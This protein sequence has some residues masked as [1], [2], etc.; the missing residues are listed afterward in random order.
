MRTPFLRTPW[1]TLLW[2]S[3]CPATIGGA[4][5]RRLPAHTDNPNVWGLQ[6]GPANGHTDAGGMIYDSKRDTLV[7]V[8]TTHDKQFFPNNSNSSSGSSVD[9]FVATLTL[10]PLNKELSHPAMT[11]LEGG[12]L[13]IVDWWSFSAKQRIQTDSKL[14]RCDFVTAVWGDLHDHY[15]A[16][17]TMAVDTNVNNTATA[18][19]PFITEIDVTQD[20]S[21]IVTIAAGPFMEVLRSEI[22]PGSPTPIYPTVNNNLI[23]PSAITTHGHTVYL[24]TIYRTLV[25]QQASSAAKPM[26]RIEL[27]IAKFNATDLEADAALRMQWSR[28]YATGIIEAKGD[29]APSVMSGFFHGDPGLPPILESQQHQIE[30]EISQLE[31][32]K[33]EFEQDQLDNYRH[34]YKNDGVLVSG[35]E[36]IE[37]ENEAD[38][39]MLISGSAPGVK[40]QREGG[41]ENHTTLSIHP[42]MNERGTYVGDWDGFISKIGA[43]DGVPL[44]PFHH[45]TSA[46]TSLGAPTGYQPGVTN[47]WTYT[48]KT[49]PRRDD[50]VQS[51]CVPRILPELWTHDEPYYPTVAYAIGSTTGRFDGNQDGG[52][53]VLQL[54][55][56]TMNINWKKQLPGMNV[57][58]LSC[59]VLVD[60]ASHGTT[61]RAD[62]KDLLYIAGEVHGQMTVD[63]GG[64]R[65][66]MAEGHG[67]T[68]IWVA[69]L[70]AND[71]SFRWFHQIGTSLQDRLAKNVNNP[72]L[73][74]GREEAAIGDTGSGKGALVLDRHG[75]ALVYGTTNGP[76]AKEKKEPFRDIFVLRLHR[77]DGSYRAII[78]PP[79]TA[80]PMGTSGGTS[81]TAPV[82]A[83]TSG[84]TTPPVTGVEDT[85][86]YGVVAAGLLIPIA[87]GIVIILATRRRP[88]SHPSME[89]TE[90]YPKSDIDMPF[91]PQEQPLPPYVEPAAFAPPPNRFDDVYTA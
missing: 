3:S 16:A 35:L 69:Q 14:D 22:N 76:F 51:I 62:N 7:L 81:T 67:E 68:D 83:P 75:N 55:L 15:F 37:T 32:E 46:P 27:G 30:Q 23:I 72:T 18:V 8:G 17:G 66:I 74:E 58:G 41:Y 87:L 56:A 86:D 85:I 57:Q 13:Q 89:M 47:T 5:S 31:A 90:T 88:R 65:V 25:V 53:F 48:L 79:K 52:A 73:S 10:P 49:Q 42:F 40:E 2:L 77:D 63:L 26:Y 43:K 29:Q 34:S 78:P 50:F 11:P 1:A 9:C 59:Q 12:S 39:Y 60:V 33:E 61:T 24:A 4:V 45:P 36:I 21:G 19:H 44:R 71:G 38:Q 6:S 28:I 91:P 70:Q 54:D 20:K 64:G 82:S 84:P 80:S